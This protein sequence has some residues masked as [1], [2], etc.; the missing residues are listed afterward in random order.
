MSVDKKKPEA[1]VH[2]GPPAVVS[3]SARPDIDI[4]MRSSNDE[5]LSKEVQR[6]LIATAQVIRHLGKFDIS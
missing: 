6:K 5:D 4:N 2:M 3:P 1:G